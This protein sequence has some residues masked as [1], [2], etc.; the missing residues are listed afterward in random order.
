[1]PGR[2]PH[3][4]LGADLAG[5]ADVVVPMLAGEETGGVACRSYQHTLALLLALEERLTGAAPRA[6]ATVRAA[7]EASADLLA[8]RADWLPGLAELL[9]GPD[10][11]H[12]S[13]R[14]DGSHRLCRRR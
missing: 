10:G 8:R 7:A 12:S 2:P 9:L 4:S 14:P 11:T 3:D 5:R 6:S 1:M 13:R